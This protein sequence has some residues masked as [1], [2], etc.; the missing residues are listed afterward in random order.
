MRDTGMCIFIGDFLRR[1]LAAQLLR[2]LLCAR[3]SLS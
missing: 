2:E 3:Q 1:R